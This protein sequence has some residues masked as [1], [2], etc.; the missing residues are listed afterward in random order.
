MDTIVHEEQLTGLG[1]LRLRPLDPDQHL[2]LV[3]QW[4]TQPRAE[5]WGM[6]GHTREEVREI[7]AFLAGLSTHHAYLMLLDGA[8][9]GIFQTYQP[10]ADPVG[11]AYPVRP[12]DVGIHLFLAAP[13]LRPIPDFTGTLAG[14]LTRYLFGTL[15]AERIVVEPDVRNERALRRWRRLGFS[16]GPQVDLAGKRAQLAFLTRTAFESAHRPPWYRDPAV[17]PGSLCRDR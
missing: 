17:A 7:Y 13:R 8:P 2:D 11:E 9:V 14:S 5:F 6:T 4:V 16:F 3:Y 1:R 10:E 12:G 15:G